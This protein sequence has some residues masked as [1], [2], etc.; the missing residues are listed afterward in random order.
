MG[1]SDAWNLNHQEQGPMANRNKPSLLPRGL[2]RVPPEIEET[3]Y[4]VKKLLPY[5]EL[6]LAD[7][8]AARSQMRVH[9]LSGF[10]FLCLSWLALWFAHKSAAIQPET[11]KYATLIIS[12]LLSMLG[13][14]TV[15]TYVNT[16]RSEHLLGLAQRRNRR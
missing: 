12:S 3:R 1:A 8:V 16:A 6:L 13:F 7:A 10:L 11:Y 5:D 9:L 15:L 4:L 14:P 2:G